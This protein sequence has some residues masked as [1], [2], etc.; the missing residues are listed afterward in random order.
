MGYTINIYSDF[1]V[2][3]S[4]KLESGVNYSNLVVYRNILGVQGIVAVIM[5]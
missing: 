3:S 5:L 1:T 4:N 2:V